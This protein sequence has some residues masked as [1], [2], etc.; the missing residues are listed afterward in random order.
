MKICYLEIL[1]SNMVVSDFHVDNVIQFIKKETT[2]VERKL[3]LNCFYSAN[4]DSRTDVEK[5]LDIFLPTDDIDAIALQNL[6]AS[7]SVICCTNDL[8]KSKW[9][10][11]PIPD[12]RLSELLFIFYLF[13]SESPL[14]IYL[15]RKY[16]AHLLYPLSKFFLEDHHSALFGKQIPRLIVVIIESM[17]IM[18]VFSL[19]FLLTWMSIVWKVVILWRLSLLMKFLN[20]IKAT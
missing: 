3:Y 14:Q 7:H 2:N 18:N 5:I 1:D 11:R 16:S 12:N 10:M 13:S 20:H 9:Q 6:L 8:L 19:L 15:K 4:S 17:H